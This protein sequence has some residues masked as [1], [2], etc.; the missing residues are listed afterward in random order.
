MTTIGY[1]DR[2]P[3][4]TEEII[5]TMMAEVLGLS[6]FA[7]LLNQIAALQEVLGRQQVRLRHFSVTSRPPFG[8]CS[9]A[10]PSVSVIAWAD[11][12]VLKISGHC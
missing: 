5:Y 9:L 11:R 12:L 10:F 2:G 1:G 8:H 4:L 3:Q 6:F 7:M